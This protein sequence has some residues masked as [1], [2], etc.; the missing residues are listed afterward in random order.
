M[1][2]VKI[3]WIQKKTLVEGDSNLLE[4]NEILIAKSEGYTVLRERLTDGSIKTSVV[5][6]LEEFVS[7]TKD[8]KDN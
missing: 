4:P 7:K 2:K 8:E 3:G 1:G 6:P 5:V